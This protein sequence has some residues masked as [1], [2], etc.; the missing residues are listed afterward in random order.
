[1]FNPPGLRTNV[2]THFIDIVQGLIL[3]QIHWLDQ[4]RIKARKKVL[5]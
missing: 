1:M 3:L 5:H 2:K 4:I